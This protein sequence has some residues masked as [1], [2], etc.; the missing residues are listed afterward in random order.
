MRFGRRVADLRR[1][2]S[3]LLVVAG[4]TDR[5]APLRA[6]RAVLAAVGSRDREFFVAPGGHMGVFAGHTALEHVWPR[7][8][9]W[10]EPRSQARR[11]PERSR[12]RRSPEVTTGKTE[13]RRRAGS[14]FAS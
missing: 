1:V 13:R 10:L 3:S 9:A 6:V 7:I 14:R 5:V 11:A 4:R 8:A 2:E 12:R